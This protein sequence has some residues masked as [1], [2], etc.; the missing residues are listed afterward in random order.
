MKDELKTIL[1]QVRYHLSRGEREMLDLLYDLS[2]DE[3]IPNRELFIGLEEDT[4]WKFYDIWCVLDDALREWAEAHPASQGGE[5][6]K[7]TQSDA[8]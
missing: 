6:W 5:E 2:N 8:G 4:R 3:K 7:K 1:G